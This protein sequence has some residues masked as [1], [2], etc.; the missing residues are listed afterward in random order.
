M[1][2]LSRNAGHSSLNMVI[3]VNPYMRNISLSVLCVCVCVC[4]Q[5]SFPAE[6]KPVLCARS[7]ESFLS[8]FVLTSALH[9]FL[10]LFFYLPNY[11]PIPLLFFFFVLLFLLPH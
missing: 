10:L 5:P 8:A 11:L 2:K 9:L 4:E 6:V 3:T 1:L 7:L